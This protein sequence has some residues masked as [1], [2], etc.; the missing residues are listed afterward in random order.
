MHRHMPIYRRRVPS[1]AAMRRVG[2]RRR[3]RD[4]PMRAPASVRSAM[5]GGGDDEDDDDD[6]SDDENDDENDD[7]D[8]D[9]DGDDDDANG[10]DE[11]G[12]DE[13][14]SSRATLIGEEEGAAP[15][16]AEE[17]R[18]APPLP[19]LVLPLPPPDAG[20]VAVDAPGAGAG[21]AE[22]IAGVGAAPVPE[23]NDRNDRRD[24]DAD[25]GATLEHLIVQG[26]YY[27]H[28][29][30][31]VQQWKRKER[32]GE[33]DG[34]MD[35]SSNIITGSSTIG[36]DDWTPRTAVKRRR[37]VDSGS[38]AAAPVLPDV[39]AQDARLYNH[40]NPDDTSKC[41]HGDD[42]DPWP[43]TPY[44]VQ[45]TVPATDRDW[46][47]ELADGIHPVAFSVLRLSKTAVPPR[48]PP[49][50]PYGTKPAPTFVASAAVANNKNNDNNNNSDKHSEHSEQP[51]PA[52]DYNADLDPGRWAG[53]AT[54]TTTTTSRSGG[55]VA[56]SHAARALLLQCWE[57]AVHAAATA[58][59]W[60]PSGPPEGPLPP[61]PPQQQPPPGTIP[62][63]QR[64]VETCRRRR[65]HSVPVATPAPAASAARDP[66]RIGDDDDAA[67]PP[68]PLGSA[69]P[70]AVCG[71]ECAS[72]DR[73][74]DH[75]FGTARM[76]GCCW[77]VVERQQRQLLAAALMG[78]VETVVPQLLRLALQAD[79]L[80]DDSGVGAETARPLLDGFDVLR[81]FEH[82]LAASRAVVVSP[83]AAAAG[84][85]HGRP[86][87]LCETLEVQLAEPPLAINAAVL[88]AVR[89]RLV[90]R[91]ARVPR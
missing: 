77:L 1:H 41:D 9:D 25:I 49:I 86:P 80:A 88:D 73:R 51:R 31:R 5:A 43:K 60:S 26:N 62:S 10:D 74:R 15:D 23:G 81:I 37:V 42:P 64:A 47:R 89:V 36:G 17:E 69:V 16:A 39:H 55:D 38:A 45:R 14:E 71:V 82:R 18:Y 20:L 46:D 52:M 29:D 53:T 19:A 7:D 54:A 63:R 91:Y 2:V 11:D 85:D 28:L 13:D 56:Q 78:E 21:P 30:W 40:H 68:P 75:F 66:A 76:S 58:V 59:A 79:A 24:I 32:R 27:R 72:E 35:S 87:V 83:T 8:G 3:D 44:T 57:R 22:R 34:G 90:D 6:D 70:C 33:E 50:T 84:T 4:R 65:I 48:P 61:P 12:D 67:P